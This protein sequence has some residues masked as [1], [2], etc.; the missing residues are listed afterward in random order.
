MKPRQVYNRKSGCSVENSPK[1]TMCHIEI[2][3]ESYTQGPVLMRHKCEKKEVKSG[4]RLQQQQ[5]QQ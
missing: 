4:R 2:Y 3:T 5:Q 1:I